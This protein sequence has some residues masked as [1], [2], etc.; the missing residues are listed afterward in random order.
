MNEKSNRSTFETKK[1]ILITEYIS[2]KTAA[3]QLN[4]RKVT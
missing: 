1:I 2:R 3:T 4:V